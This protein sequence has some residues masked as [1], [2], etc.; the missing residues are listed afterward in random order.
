VRYR[1]IVSYS[2]HAT[3]IAATHVHDAPGR[4]QSRDVHL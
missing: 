3:S 1:T 2:L 4:R